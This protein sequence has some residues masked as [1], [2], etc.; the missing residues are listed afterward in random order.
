[1]RD[2]VRL[3]LLRLEAL[4]GEL[5]CTT[6]LCDGTYHIIGGAA[7]NLRLDLQSYLDRRAYEPDE[8][9]EHLIGEATGVTTYARGVHRHATVKAF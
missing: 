7:R 5:E 6:V 4:I 2:H 3:P 8:M 1:V 9:R